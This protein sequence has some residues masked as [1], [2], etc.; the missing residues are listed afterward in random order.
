MRLKN[1]PVVHGVEG[2]D[3][4]DAHRRHLDHL[5]DS[6]HDG[7]ACPSQLSL[8]QIQQGHD[9]T[10]LVLRRILGHDLLGALQVFRGELEL[11]ISIVIGSIAVLF[12]Y[13]TRRSLL[14]SQERS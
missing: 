2:S 11:D 10:L 1:V 7:Q 12:K 4:V 14:S 8:S 9:S 13:H 5:G 6:I 3:L